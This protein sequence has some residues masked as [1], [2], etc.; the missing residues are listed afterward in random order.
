[1]QILNYTHNK[2]VKLLNNI[3]SKQ[4]GSK[5]VIWLSRAL[6]EYIATNYQQKL[7]HFSTQR[8]A[9]FCVHVLQACL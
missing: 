2:N 3:V 9:H 7:L 6:V 4:V 1:M 8:S 5:L